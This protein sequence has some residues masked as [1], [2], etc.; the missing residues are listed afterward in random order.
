MH[1]SDCLSPGLRYLAINRRM[2]PPNASQSTCSCSSLHERFHQAWDRF[3]VFQPFWDRVAGSS[4]PTQGLADVEE[5][6]CWRTG[7]GN[8]F[9]AANWELVGLE[10]PDLFYISIEALGDDVPHSRSGVWPPLLRQFAIN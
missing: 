3:H 8:G 4:N 5:I 9:L 10:I 2:P 7:T 6:L 1:P